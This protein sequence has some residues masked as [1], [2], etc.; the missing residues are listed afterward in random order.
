[1]KYDKVRKKKKKKS[2][3]EFVSLSDKTNPNSTVN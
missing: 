3:K 1:M 2:D